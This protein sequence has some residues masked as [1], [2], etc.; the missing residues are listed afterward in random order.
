MSRKI[1]LNLN[2]V[3]GDLEIEVAVENGRIVDAWSIGT[4]YR[5]F[6]QIMVGRAPMDA[7]AITPRI[8]GICGT[9][10]LMAAAQALEQAFAIPV[11]ANAT[12]VRNLCLMAEEVQ[13][14]SRQTF[15]M[16]CIDLCNPA[17]AALPGYAEVLA[18]FEEMKGSIYRQTIQHSK[19]LLEIVALF[20]GQWPHSSYMV[21]GGVTSL[22]SARHIADAESII[23]SYIDWYQQA[24]LGGK[25]EDWLML[26]SAEDFEAWIDHP[27]RQG[28][29]ITLFTRFC[30]SAGIGGVGKGIDLFLSQ[31]AHVDPAAWAPPFVQRNC[32]RA[33]GLYDGS[34]GQT[35][36]YDQ[37]LVSEDVSHS[38]F[39]DRQETPRH[40]FDGET[41]PK[42]Q[43]GGSRYSW[44]K[45]P[46]YDGKA[47]QTGALA[48]LLVAGDPLTRTMHRQHGGGA[49]L[50]Q[51]VRFH[52]PASTL[53]MLRKTLA[54][55][56]DPA[57][58]GA[59]Y[60]IPT[61]LGSD[62]QGFGLVEAAR[63]SLGHW[64]KIKDGRIAKY[65][66]ITPTAWSASPRDRS[67]QRGHYEE[68]L[69][70]LPIEDE[71]DPQAVGH[72]IRSNDPCLVC[73]VHFVHSGKRLR[74]GT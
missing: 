3:E 40:P 74:L 16:F 50:R 53:M 44:A 59:P 30:R 42:Y 22:H 7:L 43:P 38:W 45:A 48:Q 35:S 39:H 23:E 55:L 19:R 68:S 9:A 29:A 65:Q 12:R 34:S 56:A 70:G 57:T 60:C 49:W 13:S 25:L 27:S 32:L 6:E 1:R 26:Q 64:V 62:G 46:R 14:D 24:I 63:G 69:I 21:P 58:A 71:E 20:G 15:L 73:T 5:G 10:H 36:P 47:V 51:F 66:I 33:A 54:D 18:A 72:V 31:G 41:I 2:R 28:A 8:C 4:L 11:P 52:R 17:Y 67:G 61:K 37:A